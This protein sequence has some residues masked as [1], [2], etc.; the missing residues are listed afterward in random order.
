MTISTQTSNPES[1]PSNVEP[2]P[3][4]QEDFEEARK[5]VY[6]KLLPTKNMNRYTY[7]AGPEQGEDK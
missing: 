1:S 5:D 3:T 4:L 6:K 7:H 2:S